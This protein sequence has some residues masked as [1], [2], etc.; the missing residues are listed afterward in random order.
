MELAEPSLATAFARCV[1]A[2]ARRIVVFPYFLAPGRHWSR[3]IPDLAAAAAAQ[4][5]GTT[6]L[7][8]A[9]LGLHPLMLQIMD[10]RIRHCLAHAQGAA[11]QCSIC[12]ATEGCQFRQAAGAKPS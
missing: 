3:D 10:Q 12:E 4:H 5:P 9:P 1:A 6:Y 11:G 2:G 8:A 7:V